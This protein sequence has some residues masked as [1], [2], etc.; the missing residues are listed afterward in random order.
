[1]RAPGIFCLYVAWYTFARTFLEFLRT[2]DAHEIAG[3][4]LNVFVS[5]VLFVA[6]IVCFWLSQRHGREGDR[7]R[8][9]ERP[10]PQPAKKMAVPKSR[11]RGRR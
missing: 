2:D 10:T 1:M 9:K 4:R 7:P 6:A 11:V 8:R 5:A 3:I